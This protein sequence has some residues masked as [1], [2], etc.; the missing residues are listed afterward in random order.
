MSNPE[1]DFEKVNMF[2]NISISMLEKILK[3]EKNKDTIDH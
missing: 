2:L 1:L 3:F